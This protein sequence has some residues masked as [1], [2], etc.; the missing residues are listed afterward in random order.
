MTA[1]AVRPSTSNC[2]LFPQS[3]TALARKMAEESDLH[4][5]TPGPGQYSPEAALSVGRQR[6]AGLSPS[7]PAYGFGKGGPR[8]KEHST[9]GHGATSDTTMSPPL[10]AAYSVTHPRAAAFSFGKPPPKHDPIAT[11]PAGTKTQTSPISASQTDGFGRQALSQHRTSSGFAFGGARRGGLS[12]AGGVSDASPGPGDYQRSLPGTISTAGRTHVGSVS[13]FRNS[14]RVGFGSPA[15]HPVRKSKQL[16]PVQQSEREAAIAAKLESATARRAAL[17]ASTGS[18]SASGSRSGFGS[19]QRGVGPEASTVRGELRCTHNACSSCG[20]FRVQTHSSPGPGSYTLPSAVGGGKGAGNPFASGT[21]TG[22]TLSGRTGFTGGRR[23]KSPQEASE[24]PGPG[25]YM[26]GP[27]K[28]VKG[29]KI[30]PL[31]TAA[32]RR[33]QTHTSPGPGD[34]S[35]GIL[36]GVGLTKSRS[37]AFS[38][39]GKRSSGGPS[40][41]PLRGR[42]QAGGSSL[43][44]GGPRSMLGKQVEGYKRSAPAFG[45]GS[46]SRDGTAWAAREAGNSPGPGDYLSARD[47]QSFEPPERSASVK[48]AR[49]KYAQLEKQAILAKKR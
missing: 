2:C 46:A 29:G 16:S 27:T 14:P 4:D 10:D 26:P 28:P 48:A 41:S 34:Y 38:L 11:P 17:R 24:M 18:L 5:S 3:T 12:S 45:F 36:G 30:A 7:P 25:A 35:D 32:R 21:S 23:D 43:T 20:C 42:S 37:P 19:G 15:A 47:I 40:I 39:G 44:E 13:P 8:F 33:P 1:V 6:V 49:S 9:P 22:P 31:S